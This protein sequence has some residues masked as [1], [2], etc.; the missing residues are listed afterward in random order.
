MSGH[1][2]GMNEPELKQY[3]TLRYDSSYMNMDQ[4]LKPRALG[5][6]NE[7]LVLGTIPM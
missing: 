2:F 7:W 3:R 1:S 4:A 5:A 6:Y